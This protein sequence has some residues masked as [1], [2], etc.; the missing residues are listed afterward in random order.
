MMTSYADEEYSIDYIGE[1]D[2]Y[3]EF[4]EVDKNKWINKKGFNI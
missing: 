1:N 3:Y 2:Y 4:R